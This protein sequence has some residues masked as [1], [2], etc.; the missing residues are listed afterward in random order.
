[1]TIG[2]ETL[3]LVATTVYVVVSAGVTVMVPEVAPGIGPD[4]LD[5]VLRVEVAVS[6]GRPGAS[7]HWYV[8]GRL[9]HPA[10]NV[11]DVLATSTPVRDAPTEHGELPAAPTVT[12]TGAEL[13]PLLAAV[14]VYVAMPAICGVT[15]RLVPG[16]ETDTPAGPDQA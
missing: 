11:T 7:L 15:S 8:V 10:V 12:L 16:P 2:G 6:P 13:P 5:F 1:M 9:S 4:F 3:E 14:T